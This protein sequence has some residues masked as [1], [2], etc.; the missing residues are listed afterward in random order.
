MNNRSTFFDDIAKSEQLREN[1]FEDILLIGV[2][3]RS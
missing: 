2:I 1:S 3:H